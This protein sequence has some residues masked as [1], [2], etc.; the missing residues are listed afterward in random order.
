MDRLQEQKSWF[1]L[2]KLRWMMQREQR[3]GELSGWEVNVDSRKKG[4]FSHFIISNTAPATVWAICFLFV[5]FI[6]ILGWY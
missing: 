5:S 3:E 6:F 1:N 4:L 2:N